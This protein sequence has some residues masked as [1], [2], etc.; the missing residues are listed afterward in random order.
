MSEFGRYS[1]KLEIPELQS[2]CDWGWKEISDTMVK[3]KN[4][5][6]MS[7]QNLALSAMF[8]ATITFREADAF[9]ILS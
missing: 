6:K 1:C 7:V 2:F 8:V 5:N 9:K 3:V 4:T